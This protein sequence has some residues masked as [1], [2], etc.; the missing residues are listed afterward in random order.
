MTRKLVIFVCTA[1]RCRSLLAEY[2]LRGLLDG[3]PHAEAVEAASAGIMT[4]AYWRFF[5][6]FVASHGRA[7]RREDFY[8]VPPYPTTLACLRKRGWEAGHYRSQPLTPTLVGRAALVIGME[9]EHKEAV[10]A[11]YPDLAGRVLTLRELAGETGPLL[12]EESYYPPQFDPSDPHYVSYSEDYVETSYQEIERCL[13]KGLPKL[14]VAVNQKI[15]HDFE[16]KS[17]K[18][19]LFN[20]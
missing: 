16:R 8:G 2:C 11:R 20:I 5:E 7:V 13:L 10:L 19:I 4:D 6:D 14:F 1:N 12:L 17:R 9:E 3:T 18:S 15:V